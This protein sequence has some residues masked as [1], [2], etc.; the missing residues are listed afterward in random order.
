MEIEHQK[1]T[2]HEKENQRED[3]IILNLW[4]KSLNTIEKGSN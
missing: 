1:Y 4:R 3:Q 2:K